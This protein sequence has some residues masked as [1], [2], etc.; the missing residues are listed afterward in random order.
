MLPLAGVLWVGAD[1]C[2]KKCNGAGRLFH[3]YRA[4]SQFRSTL[5]CSYCCAL[6]LSNPLTRTHST[7]R[8]CVGNGHNQQICSAIRSEKASASP[9]YFR[10][11]FC[12]AVAHNLLSFVLLIYFPTTR[13]G[14]G[15]AWQ[16]VWT[17]N[18]AWHF[19]DCKLRSRQQ[20]CL[21][22]K[23]SP[24]LPNWRSRGFDQYADQYP[25]I[26]GWT[27]WTMTSARSEKM[28]QN[29]PETA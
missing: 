29:L 11:L 18:S 10:M 19:L 21:L 1:L 5:P 3:W 25:D 23:A 16:V 15:R 26:S 13:C 12:T 28:E 20:N 9:I 8:E 4:K 7:A 27:Q 2:S 14:R 24:A 22:R 6:S 17:E